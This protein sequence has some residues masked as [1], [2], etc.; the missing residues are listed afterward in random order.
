MVVNFGAC[1]QCGGSCR[2]HKLACLCRLSLEPCGEVC[3]CKCPGLS[4]AYA[5]CAAQISLL[6]I[7]ALS[8]AI[9]DDAGMAHLLLHRLLH[10]STCVYSFCTV[11]EV[12]QCT[13]CFCSWHSGSVSAMLPGMHQKQ[14]VRTCFKYTAMLQHSKSPPSGSLLLHGMSALS[15]MQDTALQCKCNS[16]HV[17]VTVTVTTLHIPFCCSACC[18]HN[19]CYICTVPKGCS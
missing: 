9:A 19:A 2:V 16:L 3:A 15:L 18:C 5:K 12:S 17:H 11:S 13:Y 10:A 6:V 4:T 8:H 1:S 7:T 14:N